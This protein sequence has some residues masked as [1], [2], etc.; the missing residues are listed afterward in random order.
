MKAGFIG[1]GNMGGA[2]AEAVKKAI[3]AANVFVA[4][5]NEERTVAAAKRLGIE[6]SD[7]QYIANFCDVVF[8]G[9]KPNIVEKAIGDIAEDLQKRKGV[10]L[11][12]MAA[13]VTVEKIE[14]Y[15]GAN[16]PVIRIMPNTSV[17]VGEG[18]VSYV[19]GKFVTDEEEENFKLCLKKAGVVRELSEAQ[20]EAA[21]ALAGCGPAFV[22]KFIE[23]LADAGVEC[24]LTREI[25]TL[26]AEQTVLG[27][28][29]TAVTTGEDPAKLRGDVCS[30]GGTTIA[31]VH[32]LEKG[33]FAGT[34][35]D[36]VKASYDKTFELLKK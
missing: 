4:D 8:I 19:K 36:A 29:K 5:S 18:V 27:A 16:V 33:C 7:N 20:L 32:A 25:A 26:Y 31:G 10:L 15:A 24:G 22:Y 21:G 28:A 9:V 13:G 2:L 3:G 14:S 6:A 12:C 30:P 17:K 23:A 34:V 1:A 11:V 35:M